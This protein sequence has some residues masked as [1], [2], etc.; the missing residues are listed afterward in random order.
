[1]TSPGPKPEIFPRIELENGIPVIQHGPDALP[2][3]T[4]MGVN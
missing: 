2:I 1:V 4:E 3:T